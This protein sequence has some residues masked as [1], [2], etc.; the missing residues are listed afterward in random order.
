MKDRKICKKNK[1]MIVIALIIVIITSILMLK[2]FHID[3]CTVTF[4]SNGGTW[5]SGFTIDKNDTIK[6][7]ED[8]T[9]K[10]YI[11]EG[12]YCNDEFYDFSQPVK[13][14]I[15]LEAR[16]K[17]IKETENNNIQNEDD[18]ISNNKVDESFNETAVV[19]F[20]NNGTT[21]TVKV[22]KGNTISSPQLPDRAGYTFVSWYKGN[23]IYDFNDAVTEDLT[24]VAQWSKNQYK[25]TWNVD[26]NKTEEIYEYEQKPS[27]KKTTE[28][29]SDETY[30]YIF[31]GW[32]KEIAKV[33]GN[34]TYTATYKEEYINYTVK[35]LDEDGTV[36]S[37]KEYHYGD[38]IQVPSNPSKAADAQHTYTF[39]GWDKE[40]TTVTGNKTYTA[41]YTK[42]IN[43]YK[44]TWNV[45]GNITE[46]TYEY[47]QTPTYKGITQKESTNTYCY[48]FKGWNKKTTTVTEN[49]TYI[50]VYEEKYIEYEIKFLNEDGTVL[51]SKE[52]H[53]GD[54]V[55]VPSNPS[56]VADAQYTYTFAGWDKG[57]ATTVTGNATYTATYTNTLKSYTITFK[58]ENGAQLSRK[59]Y[60][61]GDKI[62]VPSNPSKAADE[63]YTYTFNG[64]DKEITEVTGNKT[65]TATY[66]KTINKYKVKWKVDG[67][68]T[69]EMYEYGQTP[70]YKGITQKESTNTYYYTFTGWN[71]EITAVTGNKT[72]IAVFKESYIEYEVKFLNDD[73]TSISSKTY[74]YGDTVTVPKNPSKAATAQY[75]YAFAGWDKTVATTV[76][77]NVTYS[78]TYNKTLNSYTVTFK[79][80]NGTQLSSKIYYY[81][82][83][84]TVPSNPSKASTAQYTYTFAG[85]DKSVTTVTG[86]ATYTATYSQTVRKYDI[87]FKNYNGSVLQ[88][89]TVEYGKVPTYT[90]STPKKPTSSGYNYLFTGWNKTLTQV[91]GAATYKAQ[92]K[93]IVDIDNDISTKAS[94]IKSNAFT[95][96]KSG[97][98]V[99]VTFKNKNKKMWYYFTEIAD[100]FH[101]LSSNSHFE[102]VVLSYTYPGK[103]KSTIDLKDY[104]LTNTNI[105][106]WFGGAAND[107]VGEFLGYLGSGTSSTT[108][109]YEVKTGD[110][111]GKTVD[112]TITLKDG[113]VNTDGS[114]TKKYYLKFY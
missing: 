66:T 71:K 60:Y 65:Y 113:Y 74:H 104:D 58:N 17:E 79:N 47:G 97:S 63:Q 14:N 111:V 68:I 44:V 37:S 33:T 8:P 32:D 16:W 100:I 10:G 72:Y 85:W 31:T 51:S 2:L 29:T 3:K 43:K 26:G 9:K 96:T 1:I 95:V 89:Q 35:F 91:T 34:V 55:E 112:V 77:G 7:P 64:W 6:I 84:V 54:K 94:K 38:T 40:I 93:P 105:F 76:T 73:G 83:T 45:D 107:K 109:A 39:A 106:D 46:E 25:V 61:Y 30:N 102:S 90:G 21:T 23:E 19:K 98:N 12:W 22:L 52:Y 81:G 101:N 28:K 11:F 70:T 88:T 20:L 50:A 24:L 110:L 36:L 59:T 62:E 78:A 82:D 56:K 86:N 27:Y 57:V 18:S 41:T 67:K 99:K 15:K 13:N 5:V 42:T 4:E 69:E 103:A 92:F 87:V 108:A 114:N 75:T 53:Y 49:T 48:T 80:E